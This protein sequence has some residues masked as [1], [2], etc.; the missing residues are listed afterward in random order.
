MKKI[1]LLIAILFL[2]TGC[3]DYNEL[4]NLAIVSGIAVSYKDGKYKATFEI[5]NT[6]KEESGQ[7]E[8]KK[9][10]IIS[11]QG[12]NPSDAINNTLAKAEKKVLFSHVQ[13]V[14]LDESIAKKGI[15]WI[16]NFLF[17]DIK[18][19]NNFYYVLVKDSDAEEILKTN[20]K[21][22]AIVTSAIVTLF[23]N[24]NDNGRL[25]SSNEFDHIYAKLKDGKEDIVL[26]AITLKNKTITIEPPG[27]FKKDKLVDYFNQDEATIY[28][29]LKSKAENA[30]FDKKTSAITIYNNKPGFKMKNKNTL[31]V[32]LKA[33]AKI[34]CLN[35]KAN[36]REDTL[37]KE[38]TKEYTK[39]VEEGI[40]KLLD[41]SFATES[42]F[43]GLGSTYFKKYPKSYSKN[44]F[45]ELKYE[46]DAQV[47][48][49]R[50][51]KAF[52][53]IE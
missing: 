25:D 10:I 4:N 28:Y 47:E 16:S 50:N 51:G 1:I 23:N 17:R 44:K 3:Y 42:D 34:E 18:T 9:P 29:L 49:N 46:V 5:V 24:Q 21:D 27:I 14:L 11:A 30:F 41:K 33:Q 53:V 31:V 45:L 40:K 22:Q 43:L 19:N 6:K 36:L 12:D 35:Q 39:E 37:N 32:F 48:V 8:D 26:P 38:L 13:V 52:E 20:I 7:S 15:K 2:F